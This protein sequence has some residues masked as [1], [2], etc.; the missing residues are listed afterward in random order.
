MSFIHRENCTHSLDDSTKSLSSTSNLIASQQHSFHIFLVF[1]L[2]A[3]RSDD[4]I[5]LVVMI[6]YF[7]YHFY[8]LLSERTVH[9]ILELNTK[10]K[11]HVCDVIAT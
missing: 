1:V 8:Y 6:F 3:K 11:F 5:K 9:L 2:V 7:K 4:Q 10:R